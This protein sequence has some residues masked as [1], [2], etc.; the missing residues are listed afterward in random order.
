MTTL[1]EYFNDRDRGK[2]VHSSWLTVEPSVNTLEC[3]VYRLYLLVPLTPV[4][5]PDLSILSADLRAMIYLS[6]YTN[7]NLCVKWLY[8][9]VCLKPMRNVVPSAACETNT[10]YVNIVSQ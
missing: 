1:S 8:A 6:T 7:I 3:I 5:I 2:G 10:M 4:Y 9:S